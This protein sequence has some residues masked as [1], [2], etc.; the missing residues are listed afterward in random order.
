MMPAPRFFSRSLL[1]ILAVVL[2]ACS[3]SSPAPTACE[4]ARSADACFRCQAQRCGAPLD[5]CY[6]AGFHEGRAVAAAESLPCGP[7]AMCQQ[8]CGCGIACATDCQHTLA[9][10]GAGGASSGAHYDPTACTNCVNSYLTDCVRRSCAAECG[11][12]G[13][14]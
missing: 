10:A 9:D 11:A 1:A 14:L 4:I 2:A 8:S 3:G 6:G 12:D 13:G 5:R 7:L